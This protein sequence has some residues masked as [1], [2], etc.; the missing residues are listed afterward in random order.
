MIVKMVMLDCGQIFAFMENFGIK[1]TV[2]SFICLVT[3]F[4]FK[5]SKVTWNQWVSLDDVYSHKWCPSETLVNV[6]R[7]VRI[8]TIPELSCAK[9]EFSLCIECLI[10]K[11]DY[12][13]NI[14]TSFLAK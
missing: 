9:W 10:G 13:N 14:A 5:L 12:S 8:G 11:T 7:K 4:I 3:P 2:V 1:H 6:L